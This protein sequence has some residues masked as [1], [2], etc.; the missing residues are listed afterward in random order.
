MKHISFNLRIISTR[1]ARENSHQIFWRHRWPTKQK[2][3]RKKQMLI[4]SLELW[5]FYLTLLIRPRILFLKLLAA[6]FLSGFYL[7]PWKFD[8]KYHFLRI[9]LREDVSKINFVSLV[10]YIKSQNIRSIVYGWHCETN[11]VF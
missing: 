1:A 10:V 5:T 11:A 9:K 8:V 4:R 7:L 3:W 2:K 6:C